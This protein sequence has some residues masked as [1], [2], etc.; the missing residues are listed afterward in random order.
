MYEKFYKLNED[1]F[2]ITPDPRFLYLSES[3]KQAL[4]SIIYGTEKRKGFVAITG[5]VGVGKTIIVRSYLEK[6]ASKKVKVVYLFHSN[7]AFKDLVR[8]IYQELGWKATTNEL[9]EMVNGLHIALIE[10]YRQDKTVVLIIDEAQN[11]PIKTLESLRMFSNLETTTEKLIQVVLV[12]QTE[13]EEMLERHDLRQLKQRIAI[14]SQIAPL[15]P[16]ES[17]AYIKHRLSVAGLDKPSIFTKGALDIIIK[18]ANGVPRRLNVLC[19]NAL[20]TGMGYQKNPVTATI[21]REVVTDFGVKQRRSPVWKLKVAALVGVLVFFSCVVAFSLSPHAQET[22]QRLGDTVRQITK[23]EP[24]RFPVSRPPGEPQAGVPV[25]EVP[26]PSELQEIRE[27]PAVP[28]PKAAISR[29]ARDNPK[30]A[31]DRNEAS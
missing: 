24:A 23:P 3:H 18:E 22:A 21:A 19:D 26:P 25:R 6:A 10:L 11:M 13:L 8:T 15:S 31:H 9:I 28:E 20:I 14:Q 7:V 30:T 16:Q 5:P 4:A 29:G 1:P 17:F 12:G 27:L 2:H